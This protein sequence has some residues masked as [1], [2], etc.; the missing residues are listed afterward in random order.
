MTQAAT[1]VQFNLNGQVNGTNGPI[2]YFQIQLFDDT[3]PI[4]VSNFLRYVTN[5]DYDGTIIHRDVH[6]FVMQGGG[7]KPVISGGQVTV[8][9]PIISYGTIQNE[10]SPTHSNVRGTIGM[11]RLA[12]P[13]SATNQWFINLS[14]NTYLDEQSG[15]FAVF[16]QV[17]GEGM[18]LVDAVDALPT[19]NFGG[20][21]TDIPLYNVFD[22][23]SSF[24]TV[25]SISIVP[26]PSTLIMLG[27][28]TISLVYFWRWRNQ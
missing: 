26:E 7:Y 16:G 24:V 3:A 18:K 2:N 6:N 8:L 10:F 5:H 19:Y 1:Y 28:G 17:I 23:A 13:N 9:N 15:G 14:D 21:F 25:T 22:N 11:A 27:M 12:D 20:V 4:T